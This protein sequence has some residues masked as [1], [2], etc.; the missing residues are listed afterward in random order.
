[1]G[2][3]EQVTYILRSHKLFMS[4]LHYE[5]FNML[6]D[7]VKDEP[8]FCKELCKCAFLASWDQEHAIIFAKMM[9]ELC[10]RKD[11]DLSYMLEQGKKTVKSLPHSEK[12]L[13]QLSCDFLEYPGETPDENILLKLSA[14][15]ISIADN[16]LEASRLID[17]LK[18][19]K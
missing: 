12:A 9:S 15:W 16:A 13:F 18:E 14:A 19:E 11:T 3:A 17:T 7:R 10:D 4:G 5:Q 1:M 2:L 6:L 8:F